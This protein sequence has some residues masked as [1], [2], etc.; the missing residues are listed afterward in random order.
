MT[1]HL[2]LKGRVLLW[3][4]ATVG[5]ILLIA[6]LGA[7][8]VFSRMVLGQ[9][10]EALLDLARTEAA[11]ALAHPTQPPRINERA[12]GTAPPSFE[13]L[14]KFIQIVDDNG[15][16]V[17]RSANLGTARL[18]TPPALLARLRA[19]EQVFETLRDFGNEPVRVLSFPLEVGPARYAIQVAGSLDDADAALRGARWLFLA[20][21][22]AILLAV[23]LTGAMLARAVL[24][25]SIGSSAEPASWA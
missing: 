7:N 13:R 23:T 14:D 19:G 11:A 25:P 1:W 6:A 17:A 8:V 2:N 15:D 12:P 20:M 16:V 24:R 5:L 10:D 4:V 22:A 21:A 18:P 3:H 9:F